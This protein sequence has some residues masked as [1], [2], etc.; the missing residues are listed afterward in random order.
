MN[1]AGSGT[2]GVAR[3]EFT[4]GLIGPERA[5]YVRVLLPSGLAVA[6]SIVQGDRQPDGSGWLT[7]NV[8]DTDLGLA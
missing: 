1:L 6:G 4:K 8:E 2:P 3:L 5:N 7:F